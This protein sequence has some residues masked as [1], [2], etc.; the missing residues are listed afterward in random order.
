MTYKED[1]EAYKSIVT[2]DS[3]NIEEK[4]NPAEF[5]KE[6]N[7]THT[8]ESSVEIKKEMGN[9]AE[10]IDERTIKRI[11]RKLD[12]RLIPCLWLLYFCAFSAKSIIS[13]SLT[14]NFSQ[15]DSLQQLVKLSSREVS[16][17]LSLFYLG[18]VVFEVP[19]NMIMVYITPRF[20]LSQTV[21]YIG[22]T[23][24]LH[25]SISNSTEFYIFRFM[26]GFIEAGLWPGLAYYLTLYYP[27]YMIQKRILWYFTAAQISSMLVG[28]LSMGFQ[29]INGVANLQGYKW[30]F[31]TYGVFSIIAGTI[32]M[33][34]LPQLLTETP[35]TKEELQSSSPIVRIFKRI[36]KTTEKHF[37]EPYEKQYLLSKLSKKEPWSFY[38]FMLVFINPK[39]WLLII[40]YFGSIGVGIAIQIYGS[41][42]IQSIDS[43]ISDLTISLL[44]GCIWIANLAGA[45]LIISI[46]NH[47]K[48][49]VIPYI[50]CCT[51]VIIG[52]LVLTFSENTWTQYAGLLISAFG[53]APSVPICMAWCA[54]IF[55]SQPNINVATSS[56][57]L[58]SLGNLGSVFSTYALYKGMN[59]EDAFKKSNLVICVMM[60]V[61]ISACLIEKLLLKYY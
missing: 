30:L 39:I 38:K 59:G 52:M 53:I 57:L 17:G 55:A 46:S 33:L 25:I 32:T 50:F 60:C 27:S 21:M 26:L 37:F 61:S 18:Y 43:N 48:S 35:I 20:L 31:L 9:L 40:M 10:D 4:V 45:I 13:V 5:N 54:H 44:Y 8:Y 56:A 11:Y 49:R 15:G 51:T 6:G 23:C 34:T 1:P 16:I 14:M 29:K 22:I 12:F 2:D 47:Y 36:K 19:S 58:S 7:Q 24:I 41:T 3:I 28:F 42:I